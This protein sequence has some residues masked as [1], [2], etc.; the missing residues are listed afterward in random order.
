[1]VRGG[2]GALSEK[3]FPEHLAPRLSAGMGLVEGEP[4][5]LTGLLLVFHVIKV[6]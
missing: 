6:C 4:V 1:M 5:T 2:E 3:L